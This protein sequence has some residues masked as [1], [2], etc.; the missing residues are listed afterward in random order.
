MCFEKTETH[1]YTYFSFDMD[2][3]K[4][5]QLHEGA[6]SKQQIE[7]IKLAAEAEERAKKHREA[8]IGAQGDQV[9]AN[10]DISN[11]EWKQ[12]NS[13]K[14]SGGRRTRSRGRDGS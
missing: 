5:V 4:G 6:P 2:K 3:S 14:S 11:N 10:D 8:A 13:P 1:E 7:Q 9:E 12:R